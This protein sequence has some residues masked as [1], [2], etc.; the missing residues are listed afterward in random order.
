MRHLLILLLLLLAGCGKEAQD[1]EL[2]EVANTS[3]ES[4][5]LAEIRARH[6]TEMAAARDSFELKLV[7][8]DVKDVEAVTRL[9]L[10]GWEIKGV[11][12]HTAY[13]PL[14]FMQK[15]VKP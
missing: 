1:Q 13:P 6:E 8:C 4:V 5:V 12:G 11:W 3:R 15:K 9:S 7:R 10:D 2:G 14:L